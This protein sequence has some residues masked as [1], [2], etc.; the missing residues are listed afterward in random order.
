MAAKDAIATIVSKIEAGTI[1]LVTG[2]DQLIQVLQKHNLMYTMSINP[3]MVGFDLANRDG[4][5]GNVE[6][7][8]RLAD[9]IS[10]L[11]WS[12]ECCRHAL[13]VEV[14]PNDKSVENFNRRLCDGVALG[15]V[16]LDSIRFG[17]LACG[18][19][20]FVLR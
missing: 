10:A 1:G 5:G 15:E 4:Q 20:N 8:H 18:H 2:S 9:D 14:I 11:G 13:C 16:P 7:V 19:T 12:C 6:A 3:R 17:S